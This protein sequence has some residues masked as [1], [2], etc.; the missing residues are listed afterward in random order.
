MTGARRRGTGLRAA[1]GGS[2]RTG[3]PGT[4]ENRYG[5]AVPPPLDRAALRRLLPLHLVGENPAGRRPEN[6]RSLTTA[7][8]LDTFTPCL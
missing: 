7:H 1:D 8:F 2:Q 4:A 6:L 3:A 5:A